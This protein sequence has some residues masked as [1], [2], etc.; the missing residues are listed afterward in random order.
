MLTDVERT[1]PASAALFLILY[2]IRL[3]ASDL[4]DT[5]VF[6]ATIVVA[7]A[8]AWIL[9]FKRIKPL[10]ALIIF[11]ISP[12]A[13]R[14]MIASIRVFY[15]N[16]N[17][18]RADSLLLNFDRNNFVS[19]L[20]F[21]WAG[22]ATYFSLRSARALRA[23]IIAIDAFL[24]TFFCI[25][26]PSAIEAYRWPVVPIALCAFII[27]LQTVSLIMS[28]PRRLKLRRTEGIGS[29]VTVLAIIALGAA[30]FL[31]PA[32]RQTLSGGLLSPNFF[33]FDFSKMLELEHEI[34][35]M[36]NDL[37]LIVKKEAD[38][39]TLI[40]RSVLSGY[41]Q[42]QSFFR[43]EV[44][45]EKNQIDRLPN[46]KTALSLPPRKS[47]GQNTQEYFIVNFDAQAFIAMN[48]PVS[49][50]PFEQWDSSSFKSAYSVQSYTVDAM[51]FEL[52]DAVPAQ[53]NAASFGFSSEEYAL[54]TEYGRN[55][56]IQNLAAMLTEGVEE[57]WAQIQ[58][59]YEYL[60]NGNYR[61][62]LK[63]GIAPDGNQLNYFLFTSKKG[64]CSYFAF[65]FC[66]MLRSRGIPSR[67]AAGFFLDPET[68]AFNYYPVR[69]SQAHAWV[70]VFF[71][72]YGWIEYDPTTER[73]AEG[74]EF[75]MGGRT[76]DQFEALMQELLENHDTLKAK[77]GLDDE[78]AQE[79]PE[80]FLENAVERIKK[81]GLFIFVFI[82]A[83]LMILLRTGY[84]IACTL[85]KSSRKKAVF[86]WL[87]AKWRLKLAG[88]R[89]ERFEADFEWA[90]TT[91]RKISGTLDLYHDYAAARFA[92]VW[93]DEDFKGMYRH[94]QALSAQYRKIVP[95]SRRLLAW[96][97]PV[98]ALLSKAALVLIVLLL[99]NADT[100][101]AQE[102]DKPL[103][104]SIYDSARK[105]QDAELWERAIA[106]YNRGAA[107]YPED[108]RFP[109]ALGNLYYG[110]NLYRLAM[111]QYLH[112]EK[113]MPD[114][115]DLLYRLSQTSGSL[116]N[117][118][119]S[120]LY[121]ERLIAV[122]PE[123]TR[124]IGSLGWI[125]YKLHRLYDGE[126]LLLEAL[127][128]LGPSADFSMTL[129]TIYSD[130]FRYDDAARYYQE[131]ISIVEALGDRV[132]AAI[133][134]YNFSIFESRYYHFEKAWIQT[135]A[136]LTTLNRSSGRLAKGELYLRTLNF[137]GAL[138]EYNSA[139]EMDTSPLSKVSL[140]Q[141][142][143][144]AG[145]LEEAR[146]FGEE[147]LKN[148][149]SSWMLYY[150]IDP[151]G[152]KRD[153][154]EILYKTYHGLAETTDRPIKRFVYRFTGDVHKLL[155]RKY[156]LVSANAYKDNSNPDVL[157]QYV[158]AFEA[159]PKRALSYL[160]AARDFE[161]PHIPESKPSYDFQESRLLRR[162]KDLSGVVDAFDPVWEKDMR[163]AAYTELAGQTNSH[164]A[165]ENL[166]LLN[167]GALRQAGIALP[168][169]LVV[170]GGDSK[171]SK[172]LSKALIKQGIKPVSDHAS[173]FQLLVRINSRSA[174]GLVQCELN[175]TV[176][177][178]NLFRQEFV[179]LD[180]S[181]VE[182]RLLA[183]SLSEALFQAGM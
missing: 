85:S 68:V 118:E 104:D 169:Y 93:T 2:Q 66:L 62:S 162:Y 21:Y 114:N 84:L 33:Q 60:K 28:L 91:D 44:F 115:P 117:Y 111:E 165:A 126:R 140:A 9:A 145:R 12:W 42:S 86:L 79:T 133:A 181:P 4:S 150:G 64:Y 176:Q 156:S 83:L 81:A 11:F 52:F 105:Q 31:S 109:L 139:Y 6:I 100:G 116:N 119:A 50:T 56:R 164:T 101:F 154:H 18:I 161:V 108:S 173:R 54:Y 167:R 178:I 131:C 37:V 172:R 125:Y 74:E 153:L 148:T 57:Y 70:E 137:A 180:F 183:Q 94:Y 168:V 146:L 138:S 87:H 92:L 82:L 158:D 152:Y 75:A 63:P 15:A 38:E 32:Q 130:M 102:E 132:F 163:A 25:F 7:F 141:T 110:R 147:C 77:E 48:E 113:L 159:Y 41:N 124:A 128:R 17:T 127:E 73:I 166:Y 58:I 47:Y 65:A 30:L 10:L 151:D 23:Q 34:S 121:L 29:A 89:P 1:I 16:A 98:L 174:G 20:P 5:S 155:F 69:S 120:A 122:Q 39:H 8:A 22:I 177:G 71:P 143:Q 106:E 45:D 90:K 179:A 175:D 103:A 129:G 53:W 46:R 14:L 171:V 107:L 27:F 51:P 97:A 76:Q 40:R 72:G 19:L 78:S 59:L 43:H 67:V 80:S 99:V 134:H 61:Y 136:S 55:T 3:V 24:I 95:L 135:Q 36:G 149:D 26:S 144:I 49:V 96:I 157:L 13:A 112:A 182:L 142:Y 160:Y 35:Q 88:C 123:N 170:R